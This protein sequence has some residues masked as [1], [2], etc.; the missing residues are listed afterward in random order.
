MKLGY[1]DAALDLRATTAS[2]GTLLS[3]GKKQKFGT[4]YTSA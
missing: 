2:T 3:I 4:Q 1:S